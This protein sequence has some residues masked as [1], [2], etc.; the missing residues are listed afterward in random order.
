MKN[1]FFS[2]RR[3]HTRYALVTGVQTCALPIYR[4]YDNQDHL[5][6]GYQ[7]L[8]LAMTEAVIAIRGHGGEATAAQRWFI[9]AIALSRPGI[10]TFCSA[11]IMPWYLDRKS[12][13]LGKTRSVCLYFGGRRIIIKTKRL[14]YQVN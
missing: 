5:K 14:I 13:V 6:K 4:G 9:S 3:R 7:R 11:A 1:I 2:S 10:A 8:R 12:V